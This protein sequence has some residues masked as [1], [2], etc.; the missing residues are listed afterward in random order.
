M[1][2]AENGGVIVRSGCE[3]TSDVAEQRLSHGATV[4]AHALCNQ[5]RD[6][7]QDSHAM[8][9]THIHAYIINSMGN[10]ITH[11]IYIYIYLFIS[12]IMFSYA[13][14][15]LSIYMIWVDSLLSKKAERFDKARSWSPAMAG[16]AMSCCRVWVPTPAG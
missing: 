4:K 11:I 5:V 2:G 1:G 13:C 9:R 3:L 8:I 15:Y 12:Y 16:F 14:S 7:Q 6:V 10:A